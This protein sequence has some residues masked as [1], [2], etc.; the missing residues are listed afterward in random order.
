MEPNRQHEIFTEDDML[1]T[2]SF[3]VFIPNYVLEGLH[4]SIYVYL[5]RIRMNMDIY[6]YMHNICIF[7]YIYIYVFM[8]I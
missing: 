2:Y 1:R 3:L 6:L 5:T 7:A 8:Q 4:A